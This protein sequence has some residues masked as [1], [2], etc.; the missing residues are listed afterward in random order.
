M[1]VN[2][3]DT[4]ILEPVPT[5]VAPQS[6]VYHFQLAPVPKVPPTNDKV[7]LMPWQTVDDVADIEEGKIEVS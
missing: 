6:L 2:I 5:K 4:E 1:V 7:V 3:G